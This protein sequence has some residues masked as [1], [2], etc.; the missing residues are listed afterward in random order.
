MF[1]NPAFISIQV[2]NGLAL[3]MNLFIIA[4]GLT[5]IFGILRI[6]N[7][8][9]GAFVMLG[10]Y[11]LLSVTQLFGESGIAFWGGVV[12]AGVLLAIV[13]YAIERF[14]LRHLYEREHLLQLVFT[15]ALILVIGDAVKLVWG[16]HQH[17]ISYPPG[18]EGAVNLG[19]VHYPSYLLLLCAAGPIVA[20]ALWWFIDRSRWGRIVRAARLDR[21]MLSALG[22]NVHQV[23]SLVFVIGAVLAGVGGALAAP[24][25]AVGPGMD[26]QLIIECFI[27][28]IIGGLGS[29]WGSF[30]GSIILGFVTV[31]GTVFLSEWEIVLIYMVM[32]VVLLVR[33]WGL[34]GVPTRERD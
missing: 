20:I 24:R 16:T 28:V 25:M 21:E 22:V 14:L 1:S 30:V 8:A 27:I 5:L 7:F 13:G 2:L 12:A 23:Y 33:P 10:A 34:M 18:L 19:I 32:V 11:M 3:S 6:I 29:L 17:S 26:S 31:F 15:F 4:S 9:H